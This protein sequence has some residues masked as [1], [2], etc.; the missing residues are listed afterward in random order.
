MGTGEEGTAMS[1]PALRLGG[2]RMDTQ[3]PWPSHR[4]KWGKGPSVFPSPVLSP[5]KT[6]QA[7]ISHRQ[8]RKTTEKCQCFH[9]S[10]EGKFISGSE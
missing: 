8:R 6:A 7:G 4:T 1:L 5:Y 10:V 2:Y 3:P 9:K